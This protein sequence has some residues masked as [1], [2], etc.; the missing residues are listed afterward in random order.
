MLRPAESGE[1]PV[2]PGS[3]EQS[4]LLRRIIAEDEDE[5]MEDL[6]FEPPNHNA[7]RARNV[8]A[9]PRWH[10]TVP[11][12]A[13]EH[14]QGDD[15]PVESVI[16]GFATIVAVIAVGAL[17]AHLGV[18]DLGAQP[19]PYR[20]PLTHQVE[21]G[22][23]VVVPSGEQQRHLGQLGR[24]PTQPLAELSTLATAA[25]DS[26]AFGYYLLAVSGLSVDHPDVRIESVLTETGLQAAAQ[27]ETTCGDQ[28]TDADRLRDRQRDA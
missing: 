16:L 13:D 2:M 28:V 11:Q 10:G 1:R 17:V 24:E 5:R 12:C 22:A 27:Y 21:S 25:S 18:V 6:P 4:E 9:N 8:I 26:P 20:E 15:G 3:P 23:D 19:I 7:A 14:H